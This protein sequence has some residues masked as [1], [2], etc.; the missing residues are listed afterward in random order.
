MENAPWG[1]LSEKAWPSS[2]ELET[3]VVDGTI[4]G[5]KLFLPDMDCV[6]FYYIFLSLFSAL[7]APL[8]R[9]ITTE[10]NH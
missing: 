6:C 10:S 9:Q 2:R 7:V 5:I 1:D 8:L 3:I 4:V